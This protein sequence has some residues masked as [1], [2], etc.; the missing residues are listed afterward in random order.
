M[1]GSAVRLP[2]LPPFVSDAVEWSPRNEQLWRLAR[3]IHAHAPRGKGCI[4]R[5]IGRVAGDRVRAEIRT[6]SGGRLVVDPRSLEV[7]AFIDLNGGLWE[8]HDIAACKAVLGPGQVFYDVGAN[9]GVFTVEI[10]AA[11]HDAVEVRAFEPQPSLARSIALSAARSGFRNV[12]VH[13][14]ILGSEAGEEDLFVPASTIHASIVARANRSQRL[15]C[16]KTTIDAEVA[17]GALPP[18]DVIKMD[19]E[20]AERSV[21]LGAL[22]TIA[23][24]EPCIV[25]ESDINQDRFGYSRADLCA[26]LRFCAD[27]RFFAVEREGG[28]TPLDRDGAGP[29][30]LADSVLAVTQRRFDHTRL[31]VARPDW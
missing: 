8:G 10:A 2:E 5:W 18:P 30:K 7:F 29:T 28:F 13:P 9:A 1:A 27:Y 16:A 17:R 25:F 24:H 11:F 6:A 26:E 31:G 19:V 20:G 23:R 14:V 22:E 15:A 3:W 21:V 4:P 12:H